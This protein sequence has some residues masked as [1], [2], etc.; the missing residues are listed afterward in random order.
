M[1]HTRGP[2]STDGSCQYHMYVSL[3][4]RPSSVHRPLNP[5][6]SQ[7]PIPRTLPTSHI[8]RLLALTVTYVP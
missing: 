8:S 6:F 2:V 7:S 4:L 3:P 1:M 5:G